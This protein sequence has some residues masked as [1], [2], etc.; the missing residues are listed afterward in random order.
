MILMMSAEKAEELGYKPMAKWLAGADY[1]C[2]PKIMGIGPAYA[3]RLR[4]SGITTYE[5]LAGSDEDTLTVIIGAPAWRRANYGDWIAQARL[6]AAGDDEPVHQVRTRRD[7]DV[8]AAGV[9]ADHRTGGMGAVLA[10]VVRHRARDHRAQHADAPERDKKTR[11]SAHRRQHQ[12][13]RQRAFAQIRT[14]GA[15]RGGG[16]REREPGEVA[17]LDEF[18]VA[19]LHAGEPVEGLVDGSAEAGKNKA[20]TCAACHGAE[21]NGDGPGG[22]A[23]DPS[24]SNIRRLPRMPLMSSAADSISPSTPGPEPVIPK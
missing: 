6:A 9:T 12:A 7:T 24:P 13:F 2:D 17:Q 21:G 11:D 1:G 23:L 3:T 18:C 15:E 8:E 22:T 10:G 5:Q 4:A 16:L 19:R 14:V 20:I